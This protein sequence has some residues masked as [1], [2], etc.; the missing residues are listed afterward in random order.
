M[1]DTLIVLHRWTALIVGLVLVCTAA[2]GASLVF[3]G[4]IDRGLHPELWRVEPSGAPIPIDSI[5]ARVEARYPA[6]KVGTVSLSPVPGRAWTLS[7]GGL[8]VFVNPYTGDITG[9]RTAQQSQAT[10]SRRLHVF[11]VEL[12]AGR[13]GRTIVGIATILAFLLV[14]TGIVLWWPDKLIRISTTASWKRINFDL[15]HALGII[16]ALILIVITASGLV[17][18]FDAL[19]SAVRSL[20]SAPPPPPPQQPAG[21][22]GRPGQSFGALAAAAH[23]ALPGAA[24]MVISGGGAK[25]PA[26]VAMR[27]PE[28]HTPAGR[29]RVFIDRYTGSVLGKI[30]TRDAQLGTRIDNLKRSLHTG[31]VLGKPTEALWFLAALVMVSQVVTGVAM[32]WNSRRGRKKQSART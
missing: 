25:N 6:G 26:M 3:E 7:T 19:T 9:T 29:S 30:S 13:V 31:D 24:I 27:F 32:W 10:F 11:H 20:D 5:V 15:H 2:S 16:A 12:F 8:T 22:A 23:T 28:D 21:T 4:A 17:I 14:L 1:R 18:H